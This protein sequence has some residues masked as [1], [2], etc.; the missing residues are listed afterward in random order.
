MD[1]A[2]HTAWIGNG[3]VVLWKVLS[4]HMWV[5]LNAASFSEFI[6]VSNRAVR[7]SRGAFTQWS[8]SSSPHWRPL[9][10]HLNKFNRVMWTNVWM[11]IWSQLKCLNTENITSIFSIHNRATLLRLHFDFTRR[12]LWRIWIKALLLLLHY[13]LFL[14][15]HYVVFALDSTTTVCLS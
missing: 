5:G 1:G 6:P 15:K 3:S 2:R 10:M 8:F 14:G 13:S 11:N 7:P 9:H 12:H 4:C